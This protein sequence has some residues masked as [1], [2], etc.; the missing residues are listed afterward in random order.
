MTSF[1]FNKTTGD[2][3][4]QTKDRVDWRLENASGQAVTEGVTYEMT[5]LKIA[6][7]GLAK[8]TYQLT[9]KRLDEQLTLTLKMGSK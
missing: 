5:A 7:S 1:N 8:G 3:L 2:V 4:I 9:L 6:T